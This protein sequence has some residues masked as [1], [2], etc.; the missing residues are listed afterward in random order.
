MT[1]K[2][3]KG[4]ARVRASHEGYGREERDGIVYVN[5]SICDVGYRPTNPPVV[6]DL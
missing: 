3:R 2:R 5:A 1:F 4:R 6:I